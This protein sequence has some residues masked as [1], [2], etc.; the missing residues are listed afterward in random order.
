MTNWLDACLTSAG[1]ADYNDVVDAAR[2]AGHKVH[3]YHSHAV[4]HTLQGNVDHHEAW[5]SFLARKSCESVE[6][7]EDT[8]YAPSLASPAA[9]KSSGMKLFTF[10]IYV[11]AGSPASGPFGLMHCQSFGVWHHPY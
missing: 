8:G 10:G 5:K 9:S 3:L 6:E 2:V 7:L 4:A 1:D 11:I